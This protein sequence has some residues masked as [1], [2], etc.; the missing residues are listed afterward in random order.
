MIKLVYGKSIH[1]K[2]PKKKWVV[3]RS[4]DNKTFLVEIFETASPYQKS[5]ND[6]GRI[7]W[8]Q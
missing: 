3:K 6:I 5:D 2:V 1:I 4:F 7:F 8:E